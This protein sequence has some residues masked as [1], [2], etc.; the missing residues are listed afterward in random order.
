MADEPEHKMLFDVRGK[1]KRVIQVIYVLLAI[2]MALSLIVI[3]LPGGINPFTGS[4]NLVSADSAQV[5]IERAEKL[6]DQITANQQQTNAQ[7]EL[8]LARITAG[9]NLIEIDGEA[10][11]WAIRLTRRGATGL[12]TPLVDLVSMDI[13]TRAKAAA[14]TVG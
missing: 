5:S 13:S 1:R 7:G 14:S 6:E 2:V 3:G 10:G 8:I 12:S 11:D 9:N 4:S